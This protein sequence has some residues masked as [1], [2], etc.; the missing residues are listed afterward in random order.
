MACAGLTGPILSLTGHSAAR[1]NVRYMI[2]RRYRIF[3][4]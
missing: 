1:R 3:Y 4:P 2:K